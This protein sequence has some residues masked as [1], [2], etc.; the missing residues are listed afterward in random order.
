MISKTKILKVYDLKLNIAFIGFFL[1]LFCLFPVVSNARSTDVSIDMN[2]VIYDDGSML[3]AQLIDGNFSDGSTKTITI[4]TPK[5]ASFTNVS[6]T[7]SDGK[8]EFVDEIDTQGKLAE[9]RNKYTIVKDEEEETTQII[10]GLGDYGR[11]RFAIEYKISNIVTGYT[12]LDGLAY[13][14]FQLGEENFPVD[15]KVKVYFAYGAELSQSNTDIW[16][17]GFTPEYEYERDALFVSTKSPIKSGESF[18]LMLGFAKDLITPLE[19]RSTSFMAIR[20]EITNPEQ[21]D[22][23][24]GVENFYIVLMS[25]AL[26]AIVVALLVFGYKYYIFYK[27]KSYADEF[28]YFV[29][30]PNKGDI[31]V[32][33]ALGKILGICEES[34][35]VSLGLLSLLLKGAITPLENKKDKDGMISLQINQ[36]NKWLTNENKNQWISETLQNSNYLTEYDEY[37]YNVLLECSKDGIIKWSDLSN[38]TDFNKIFGIIENDKDRNL[39]NIESFKNLPVLAEGEELINI[40]DIK[41]YIYIYKSKCYKMGVK[42]LKQNN[43]VRRIEKPMQLKCFTEDGKLELAEIMGFDYF[44]KNFNII[45]HSD[46]YNV[47]AWREILAYSLFFDMDKDTF[48]SMVRL[49]PEIEVEVREFYDLVLISYSYGHKLAD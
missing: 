35:I 17:Y 18:T 2:V 12:E 11:S 4:D 49:Y 33:Y 5:F 42:N 32:T 31:N 44:I 23:N 22:I 41:H 46:K 1:M 36:V 34:S 19:N 6:V 43:F 25:I 9:N 20:R 21:G 10:F 15:M 8:Y 48:E 38:L 47:D 28:G 45:K 30:I 16:T 29:N 24:Q 26:L 3:V 27:M 40:K 14:F 37:L 13:N 39:R 7:N